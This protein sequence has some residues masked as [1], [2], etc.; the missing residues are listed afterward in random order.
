MFP[1]KTT[2]TLTIVLAAT[3]VLATVAPEDIRAQLPGAIQGSTPKKTDKEKQAEADKKPKVK[4]EDWKTSTPD[5]T[6]L[7]FKGQKTVQLRLVS[8]A[9]GKI[10]SADVDKSSGDPA[11]DKRVADW[12]L[13]HWSGPPSAKAKIPITV[14]GVQ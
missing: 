12:A 11:L 1:M 6:G 5:I 7:T 9:K 8:D 3:A 4:A 13:K 10:A 2:R 14:G